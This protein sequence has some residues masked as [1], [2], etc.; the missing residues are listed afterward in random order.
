MPDR[1]WFADKTSRSIT[2]KVAVAVPIEHADD[3]FGIVI[4]NAN[5]S[6]GTSR[7]FLPLTIRWTRY[8][9]IDRGPA[10][11]LAAVRRGKREGTL[12]DATAEPEFIKTLMAKIHAEET[13]RK[14]GQMIEFR[15]TTAFAGVAMRRSIP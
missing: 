9:A 14:D 6:D 13:V 3:R 5:C 12:L 7:Y 1:R 2:A 10:S 4:V 8:T 11:V 15:P